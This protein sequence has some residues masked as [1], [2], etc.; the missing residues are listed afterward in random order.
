LPFGLKEAKSAA[1]I[2]VNLE[3]T[4]RPIGGYDVLIAAI[5]IT[6]GAILV[7]HN[8]QEFDRIKYLQVADWY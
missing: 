6:H 5:A 2:R 3:K 8:T 1:E 4:G 7:T